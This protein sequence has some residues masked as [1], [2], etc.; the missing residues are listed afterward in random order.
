[1]KKTDKIL[2]AALTVL[3]GVLFLILKS[4][5]INILMTVAG[6]CL[7]V[8]GV[9]DLIGRL[10]PPAVI[11]LVAGGV[12]ILFGWLLT[13][14]ALYIVAAGLLIFGILLLYEKIKCKKKG[15]TFLRTLL[16]Y[17]VP[18]GIILIG[19]VLFF[20]QTGAVNFVFIISG[21]FAILDGAIM[22]FNALMED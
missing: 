18:V 8:L 7:I 20:N 21:I 1:M 16:E 22:L 4:E 10:V 15:D 14:A 6:V 19:I 13:A 17:A 11:K 5:L 2:I 9:V 12:I 3:M